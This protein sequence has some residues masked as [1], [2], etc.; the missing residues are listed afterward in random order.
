[1]TDRPVSVRYRRTSTDSAATTVRIRPSAD[2]AGTRATNAVPRIWTRN[3]AMPAIRIS[4]VSVDSACVAT[5]LRNAVSDICVTRDSSVTAG[6]ADPGHPLLHHAA[7]QAKTAVP[8]AEAPGAT[9]VLP[10]IQTS[11]QI[12]ALRAAR[13]GI[14]AARGTPATPVLPVIQVSVRTN[15][16]LAARLEI[17]VA[18]GQA[19]TIT[20]ISIAALSDQ[21]LRASA[22][23]AVH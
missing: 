20:R 16:L 17:F 22:I 23:H 4:R 5:I 18:R 1:M 12:R 13:M 8:A 3:W 2:V 14:F 6:H 10:A 19:A 7:A 9:A 21:V 15:A 11:I